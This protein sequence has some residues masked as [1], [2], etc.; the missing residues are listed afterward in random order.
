M[1]LFDFNHRNLMI[2]AEIPLHHPGRSIGYAKTHLTLRST[3]GSGRRLTTY[4]RPTFCVKLNVTS[5]QGASQLIGQSRA[6]ARRI[7][8]VLSVNPPLARIMADCPG[9]CYVRHRRLTSS[10]L[11]DR[12]PA[13]CSSLRPQAS[14]LAAEAQL[15]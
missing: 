12:L 10:T 11:Q 14:V 15:M 3:T 2:L 5:A 13:A 7:L 6:T 9:P 1:R 4:S 8:R